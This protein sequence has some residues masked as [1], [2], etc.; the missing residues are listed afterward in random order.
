MDI[1]DYQAVRFQLIF[2]FRLDLSQ[3]VGYGAVSN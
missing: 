3:S 1:V 2:A